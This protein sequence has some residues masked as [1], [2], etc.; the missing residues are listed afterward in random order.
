[1]VYYCICWKPKP[2]H[3]L[4]VP[5]VGNYVGEESGR[6]DDILGMERRMGLSSSDEAETGLFRAPGQCVAENPWAI[7][8]CLGND[9]QR[10][11]FRS[12]YSRSHIDP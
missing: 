11:P 2:W 4:Q 12:H 9:S 3:R 6:L 7:D 8:A 1:M 5:R 10:G